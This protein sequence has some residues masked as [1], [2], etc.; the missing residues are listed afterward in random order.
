MGYIFE[1]LKISAKR[2]TTRFYAHFKSLATL[3]CSKPWILENSCL[4]NTKNGNIFSFISIFK[5]IISW[6]SEL[7][8][9]ITARNSDVEAKN[10]QFSRKP[11]NV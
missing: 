9:E 5:M 8:D 7:G 11:H 4:F 10:G 2:L 6:S 1:K 3:T